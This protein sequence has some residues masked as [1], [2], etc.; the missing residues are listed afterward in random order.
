M[1]ASELPARPSRN[2][3]TIGMAPA[4]A[5]S[6][7]SATSMLLG[8]RRER[9]AVAREQRLVGG[10]HRFAGGERGLDRT[11]GRIALPAHQLDEHV[12]LGIGAQARPDR[13]P[14]ARA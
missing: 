7:F 9:D 2:V 6:K 8:E 4:T 12:D 14:S 11:L 13:R 1:R 10:D 5:A 3:L